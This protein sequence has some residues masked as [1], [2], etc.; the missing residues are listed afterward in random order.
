[1]VSSKSKVVLAGS[2]S[3]AVLTGMV[4][5]ANAT[6]TYEI[7]S[8]LRGKDIADPFTEPYGLE[9]N[10]LMKDK[11]RRDVLLDIIEISERLEKVIEDISHNQDSTSTYNH[12][13]T[14]RSTARPKD[15]RILNAL[16]LASFRYEY[17]TKHS[18]AFIKFLKE[19]SED[20][21]ALKIVASWTYSPKAVLTIVN[22]CSNEFN[23]ELMDG[24]IEILETILYRAKIGREFG[25][26]SINDQILFDAELVLKR[27]QERV[28]D[29][30]ALRY[31]ENERINY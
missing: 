10:K 24:K 8:Q 1:M 28:L 3:L 26:P 16:K 30:T 27:L 6:N 5:N 12:E 11:Y 17:S 15:G 22:I 25:N 31:M 2:L 14:R 21:Q 9:R 4:R 20:N 19:N 13:I 7:N 23:P 29:E 18:E